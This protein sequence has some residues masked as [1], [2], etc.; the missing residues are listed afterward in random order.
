M[1]SIPPVRKAR[2]KER[3][4]QNSYQHGFYA[5]RLFA[6]SLDRDRDGED[7]ELI[8]K[9]VRDYYEPIGF[10]EN[11]RAERI[12][13]G[14]LR[15]VRR[16]G[17]EQQVLW[18]SRPFETRSIEN[19]LRFEAATTRQLTHDIEEME[20]LQAKRFAEPKQHPSSDEDVASP[21]GERSDIEG[22]AENG[23]QLQDDREMTAHAPQSA[24]CGTNPTPANLPASEGQRE[25]NR[26]VQR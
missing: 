12:A 21:V 4:A 23:D 22:E 18:I 16:L 20:R 11:Y 14:M 15:E 25:E 24:N 6:T 1:L 7:Y 5:K 3:S 13:V 10:M 8:L 2:R 26:D 9:G 17:Y 19:I